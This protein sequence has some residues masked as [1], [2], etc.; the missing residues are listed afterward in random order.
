MNHNPEETA[1]CVLA[2]AQ[3][4]S[5]PYTS[6]IRDQIDAA[7]ASGRA[8]L[9]TS[10][11]ATSAYINPASYIWVEKISYAIEHV[12]QGYVISA[13]NAPVPTYAPET[14]NSGA[15]SISEKRVEYFSKF[16][17]RCPMFKGYP[18]WRMRAWLIE[19]YLFIPDLA[20]V[21][22]DVFDKAEMKGDGY[23][24]HLSFSWVGPNGMEETYASPQT[25]FDMIVISMVNYQMDEFFNVTMQKYGTPVLSSL[26][27]II[28]SIFAKSNPGEKV[29][30]HV[31]SKADGFALSSL[32]LTVKSIFAK[33]SPGKKVLGHVSKVDGL[34]VDGPADDET[35]T[36]YAEIYAR[37]ARFINFI[38]TYP[39]IQKASRNDQQQLKCEMFICLNAHIDQCEDNFRLQA[40][41][42]ADIFLTPRS[43]YI[44]WVRSTT[45]D[46]LDSHYSFAYFTCLLG[47]A[48]NR[49]EDGP[50]EDYFPGSKIKYIAQDC[51]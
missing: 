33:S 31:S 13:L 36:A 12:C 3:L 15:P 45:S 28:K 44:K 24:E 41:E 29:S 39:R 26:R 34:T 4:A 43:S 40:Q 25:I 30:G 14:V 1:Y 46:H 6:L 49:H 47:H 8:Y 27:S 37:L 35:S 11:M 5:L 23:I 51:R 19:G 42:S 48:A 17:F 22:L 38:W 21:C 7:I 2:L 18:A 32:R 16:Y 50:G 10:G 9:H 20:R